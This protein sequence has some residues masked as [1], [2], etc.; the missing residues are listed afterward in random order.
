MAQT[1][2]VAPRSQEK[3]LARFEEIQV[4]EELASFE[5]VLTTEQL[6]EYRDSVEDAAALFS[7]IATKH[8][9]NVL[10]KKY[11]VPSTINAGQVVELFNPPI[12]G[13]RIRVSGKVVD[14]YVRREKPYV[15]VE[16]TA[17]DEDGRLIE[18][19][20]TSQMWKPEEVGKKWG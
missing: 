20:T 8:D 17:V 13:K 16:A 5:Y 1:E 4:G 19:T 7:T 9:F 14:K 10:H 12:P 6:Q 18:R 2:G 3:P 15:V 11:R